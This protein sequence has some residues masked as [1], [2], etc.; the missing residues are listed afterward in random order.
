MKI[1]LLTVGF[2]VTWL[3]YALVSLYSAFINPD[4]IGPIAGAIPAMFAKS[5]FVWPTI[6]FIFTNKQVK[7]I[8]QSKLSK[9]P[10]K[11]SYEN[12]RTYNSTNTF[13]VI[14]TFKHYKRRI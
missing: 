4:H 2:F 14:I 1:C 11:T 9:K 6:L 5:S 3:P 12:S 13:F 10:L 7:R 8:I